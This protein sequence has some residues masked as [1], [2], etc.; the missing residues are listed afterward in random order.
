MIIPDSGKKMQNVIRVNTL[1]KKRPRNEE[2][3]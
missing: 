2:N 3:Q 1:W